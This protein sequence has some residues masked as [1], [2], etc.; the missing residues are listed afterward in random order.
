MPKGHCM[1]DDARRNGESISPEYTVTASSFFP[2]KASFFPVTSFWAHAMHATIKTTSGF[3][4]R[5]P[6]VSGSKLPL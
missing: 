2:S 3:R 1:M 5:V 6:T 4:S